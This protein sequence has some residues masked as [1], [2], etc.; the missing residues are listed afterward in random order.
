MN[1]SYT[2]SAG[3]T[4]QSKRWKVNIREIATS[5]NF[6]LKDAH[7]C[8][9]NDE[10]C[11]FCGSRLKYVAVIESQS[12]TY[13]VGFDC[14]QL[15]FGIE[16]KDHFLA[17]RLLQKMKDDSVRQRRIVEY[18][19]KFSDILDFLEKEEKTNDRFLISMREILLKGGAFTPNMERVCRFKM[20]IRREP[21][22]DRVNKLHE[23]ENKILSLKEDV[24]IYLPNNRFYNEYVNSVL[25]QVRTKQFITQKQ[26]ALLNTIYKAIQKKK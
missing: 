1:N 21:E 8:F 17:E 2:N 18:K 6:N 9:L 16:W 14:L 22:P 10:K 13:S 11:D 15:V 3:K 24:R 25:E 12:H 20:K 7:I 23:I 19:N 5:E 26:L 4:K